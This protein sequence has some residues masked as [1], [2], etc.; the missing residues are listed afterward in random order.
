MYIYICIMTTNHQTRTNLILVICMFYNN[1]ILFLDE[2][3]IFNLLWGYLIFLTFMIKKNIEIYLKS[4][5]FTDHQSPHI[6][7]STWF[8]PWRIVC[9][10]HRSPT[11]HTCTSTWFK[12]WRIV[13]PFH[14]SSISPYMYLNFDL[15]H[16][17]FKLVLINFNTD[18]IF[19]YCHVPL[20]WSDVIWPF[21]PLWVTLFIEG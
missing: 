6:C 2:L 19:I 9:P 7:T 4:V 3:E 15:N 12:P 20:K 11:H 10:F 18:N 1:S 13:C 14:R 21:W 5:H 17:H 8:K 16:E